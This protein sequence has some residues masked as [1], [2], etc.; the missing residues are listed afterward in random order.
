MQVEKSVF[1]VTGGAS[2]LGAGVVRGLVARGARVVI[3]DLNRTGGAALAAELGASVRFAETNVT[4]ETSARSALALA[5]SEFGA[6]QG[7]INCAGIVHG[8]KI[9]LDGAIRM[10]AK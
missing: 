4:D 9:R 3:A 10:Q 1:V 8:E 6:I 5:K 7:L 2:G